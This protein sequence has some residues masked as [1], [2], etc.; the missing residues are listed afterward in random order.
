M[1]NLNDSLLSKGNTDKGLR[2][3][4]LRAWAAQGVAVSPE[5]A[6]NRQ[7]QLRL[8]TWRKSQKQMLSQGRSSGRSEERVKVYA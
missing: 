8:P 7:N 1:P 3:A 4:G 2:N 6:T 5:G